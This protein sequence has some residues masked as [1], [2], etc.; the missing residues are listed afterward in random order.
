[1]TISLARARYVSLFVA[2]LGVLSVAACGGQVE[3][4]AG[5]LGAGPDPESP[6]GA[7]EPGVPSVQ[8]EPPRSVGPL[9]AAPLPESPAFAEG[10]LCA[11]QTAPL[12]ASIGAS[13]DPCEVMAPDASRGDNTFGRARGDRGEARIQSDGT[14]LLR[15]GTK[16]AVLFESVLRC[17]SSSG[18]H[19]IAAGDLRLSGEAS[20]RP[21]MIDVE[22]TKERVRGFVECPNAPGD[23]TS[24]FA[25]SAAPI[26]LGHFDLPRRQ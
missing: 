3:P 24:V 7:Q 12:G 16:D 10:G 9:D 14:L 1:M 13:P 21:C 5:T 25:Q 22:V 26:G 4:V 15:C 23:A 18:D 2:A 19:T 6:P 20:D 11:E 17:F 8:K